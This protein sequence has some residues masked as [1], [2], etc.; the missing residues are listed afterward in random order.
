MKHAKDV[1]ALYINDLSELEAIEL[2]KQLISDPVERPYPLNYHERTKQVLPAGS[3][4]QKNLDKIELF[5]ENNKMKINAG[6]SKVLIFN[7]SRKNDFPP[8]LAFKDG[9]ILEC[10]EETKLL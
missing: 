9:E 7:K 10:L 8:E 2:K 5:T 4:L 1:H 6:K 3:I